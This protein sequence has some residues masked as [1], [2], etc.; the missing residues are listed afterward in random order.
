MKIRG[1]IYFSL[2]AAALLLIAA[3]FPQFDSSEREAVLVQ[4]LMSS[5][6]RAHYSPLDLDN[7]FSEKVYDL[8]LNDLDMGRRFLTQEDV[9]ELKK[10]REE[11]DD[12]IRLGSL[13]FFDLAMQKLDAGMDK[14]QTWY[15]EILA[16]PFDFS[17]EEKAELK[18]EKDDFA[19]DDAE[20]REYWRK[21]LKYE[22]LSRYSDKL[23]E[24]EETGEEGENKSAETLEE[25]AREEV[26][27]MFDKFFDRLNKLKRADRVSQFMNT[28]TSVFDPHT[29]YLQPIDK[30]NFDITFSGRLEGIGARLMSEGDYT[31]VSDVVV[32]GRARFFHH[33]NIT[34]VGISL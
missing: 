23:E 15:Q 24:N 20:L 33:K 18:D 19:A 17:V 22:T 1:P 29:N 9:K 31:K 2:F 8:Y 34:S 6:Q 3:Y 25:E 14:T 5:L 27:D 16:Q 21:Y 4:T 30:E 26:R 11:L 32:G 28:V 13:E 10:Y 7:D 12:Q